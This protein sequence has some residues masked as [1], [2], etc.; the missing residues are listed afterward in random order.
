MESLREEV[1]SKTV[2]EDTNLIESFVVFIS[3]IPAM[4]VLKEHFAVNG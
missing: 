4:A 1:S 3:S 2:L